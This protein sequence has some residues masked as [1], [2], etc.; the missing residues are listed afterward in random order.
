MLI[1][2]VAGG[3]LIFLAGWKFFDT[4]TLPG[5]IH[6]HLYRKGNIEVP[7]PIALN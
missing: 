4:S 3:C 2:D 1:V 5:Y 7:L 6:A